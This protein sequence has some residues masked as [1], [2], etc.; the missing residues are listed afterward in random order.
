MPST[1]WLTHC[2]KEWI[3][4]MYSLTQY[5]SYIIVCLCVCC[6]LLYVCLYVCISPYCILYTCS[7]FHRKRNYSW[8]SLV[9]LYK[10]QMK[11]I[12]F[13]FSP[14]DMWWHC[15]SLKSFFIVSSRAN[16]S[17]TVSLSNS[18]IKRKAK[19]G[20]EGWENLWQFLK[21]RK[22]KKKGNKCR[23]ESFIIE[24][25]SSPQATKPPPTSTMSEPGCFQSPACWRRTISCHSLKN[26]LTPCSSGTVKKRHHLKCWL[27]QKWQCRHLNVAKRAQQAAWASGNV[28]G[29]DNKYC[30]LKMS[31]LSLVI[32]V[33]VGEC[34][35]VQ[36]D[37]FTDLWV[38]FNF[39]ICCLFSNV[40]RFEPNLKT[41]LIHWL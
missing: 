14:F 19:F 6:M 4:K 24:I 17:N 31:S 18:V 2:Q 15:L 37:K 26:L 38:N 28:W 40:N 13:I 7:C 35:Y 23:K 1:T 9:L 10:T 12:L 39:R 33:F 3:I 30:Q 11:L 22:V 41:C 34:V 8:I 25:L 16:S 36:G 32:E 20:K 5:K 21:G 27:L 29:C